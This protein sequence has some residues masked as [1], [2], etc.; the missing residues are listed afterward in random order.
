MEI[1]IQVGVVQMA[2][3]QVRAGG[4]VAAQALSQGA[5]QPGGPSTHLTH[6]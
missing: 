1:W 6:C 5:V 2:G 3:V 4:A